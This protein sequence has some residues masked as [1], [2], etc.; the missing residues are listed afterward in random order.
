MKQFFN[1][2]IIVSILACLTAQWSCSKDNLD[3]DKKEEPS[4]VATVTIGT[5]TWTTKNLDV[6]T[7]RDG[8]PIPQ[9]TDPTQWAALK[10]G[11]WCYYE[12]NSANGTIYG[13]LYNWYAV[14]GIHDTDPTTPNKTLAPS[15]FHIPSDVEWTTLTTFLG[16]EEV[17][18]NKM[19]ATTG[20][21]PFS[22]I[23]NTN[24]SGFTGL[25]S[26]WRANNGKFYELLDDGTWWSS[27]EYDRF[28]WYR[29][30]YYNDS[31]V[32]RNED[33]KEGGFSVRCLAG[34]AVVSV[35]PTVT[36]TTATAIT[37][38]TATTGGNITKDGGAAVTA[39]GVVYSTSTNPTIALT[40]K[41]TDGTGIGSF[42]SSLT[43]LTA[44]TT[45]YV[46]AYATNSTGTSYGNEISFT[47]T[48][49]VAPIVTVTIGTQTWTIKNL[50]V[51]TYRDGTPIPQVTDPTQWAS[52]KTGAW[53]YYENNSINGTIYGKLYNWYAVAGIHDTDPTTPNKTLAP[54]G[55]HIPSD[56]EWTTLTTFLGGAE[57]A[58]GKMKATGI[59]RW[60]SP[61]TGSTNSSGFTGL[62][63]GFRSSFIG[64]FGDLGGNGFW[65]SAS[66]HGTASAWAGNLYFISSAAITVTFEKE[67]GFSVRCLR[68]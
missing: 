22:G 33:Y 32:L 65:W 40:T 52:L 20:W 18:G 50:D 47:T 45:Y 35:N 7:Y 37:T 55:F 25:P 49:V 28:S 36:S 61:N 2:F 42:T 31:G 15:G 54:S 27:T 59:T 41:T 68:D 12:N 46:R 8:T 16:G 48:T 39:R 60:R 5:Q 23:T 9:I 17:A 67:S 51:A 62:P 10:T 64:G 1:K 44:N 21:K 11:A 34:D 43:G 38:T 3:D 24:S 6:D 30:I 56:A 57:V 63:G 26:G 29:D 14:A 53:C 4:T 58:G 13:K 19:K 66:E